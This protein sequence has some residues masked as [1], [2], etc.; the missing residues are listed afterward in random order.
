LHEFQVFLLGAIIIDLLYN[1]QP[2][3]DFERVT[4]STIEDAWLAASTYHDFDYAVEKCE[5]WMK[6]FFKQFLH[7]QDGVPVLLNLEGVVVRDDFFSKLRDICATINYD[8]DDCMVRFI[9]EKAVLERNHAA[10]ATLSLLNRFENNNLLTKPAT[11]QAALAVFLHEET[12]WKAFCGRGD[13]KNP[14]EVMLAKEPIMVNLAFDSLPLA[15]LLAYCD[16]A[17][18]WGRVGRNYEIAKPQFVD[19]TLSEQEVSVL[20]KVEDDASFDDK[21][22][23][24]QRL[25]RFLKDDRFRLAIQL[26]TGKPKKIRMTGR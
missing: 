21:R 10:L 19:I 20:I 11:N 5:D 7:I 26:R 15:F 16:T 6:E 2:I 12:I 24:I 13:C 3:R 9:F 4:G 22:R 17:Q 23:E 25:K 1:T 14:W 18:E 8:L